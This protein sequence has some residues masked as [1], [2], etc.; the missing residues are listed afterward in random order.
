M[1]NISREK[2]AIKIAAEKCHTLE[3][4]ESKSDNIDISEERNTYADP[5]LY[6][7]LTKKTGTIEKCRRLDLIK[8]RE[9]DI[10]STMEEV[11]FPVDLKNPEVSVVIPVYNSCREL[12]ECLLSVLKFSP[13]CSW[14]LIIADDCSTE[15]HVEKIFS[16]RQDLRYIKQ[17]ENIGF[18]KNVNNAVAEAKGE[19]I[20]L[21][22]SDVQLLNDI[23]T[24][25]LNEIGGDASVGCIGPKILFPDGRL[26]EAGGRIG[27]Y[28][29]MDMIGFGDN[30]NKNIYNFARYVD[31]ISGACCFFRKELFDELN[32]LDINYAPAYVEDVDFCSRI[33]VSGKKI[34][35]APQAEIVHHLSVS[36]NSLSASL[37]VVQ[38][39]ANREKFIGKFARYYKKKSLLKVI[40][41]YLPQFHPCVE[42]DFWWGK[43]YTE[44]VATAKASPLFQGHYQPHVPAELGFYNLTDPSVFEKQA[45][46]ARR[47][48]VFGFCFYYYN[49][50]GRELLDKALDTFLMSKADINFCLCWAN[51]NWTRRWD[52]QD[53]EILMKQDDR[54]GNYCLHILDG[55]ERFI[56]D[57]RYIRIDGRPLVVIYRVSL[58]E[59]VAE[60]LLNWREYWRNQHDEELYIC[61]V[62][63]A[64]RALGESLPP[65]EMGFDAAVEFPV[66]NAGAGIE[67]SRVDFFQGV[68]CS[69]GVYDYRE[70]VE[71]ICSRPHPGYKRFPGCFPSWD[72][73]PRK[74]NDFWVFNESHPSIFQWFVE[75]KAK[76]ADVLSGDEKMLFVNAWNEWGEGAHIEPDV[77]YGHSWLQVIDRV[78]RDN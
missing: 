27:K 72:N 73:T 3:S 15:H 38:S 17:K 36:Y 51:E 67:Q 9:E 63:S 57:D 62:D 29:K 6:S 55:F 60:M 26:Q 20:L 16:A 34:F 19:Y 23:V 70:A 50:N 42:N 75:Q 46:L 31:Y 33:T 2:S 59:N 68:K 35:Y 45:V 74:K 37:K 5:K 25:F 52:G 58:L 8:V 32:G 61:L 76:E 47:Y 22:N 14:E 53:S 24:V 66:H 18:L 49:F 40:A 30:P 48:N 4:P 43:N 65:D 78:V 28:C 13:M 21:L 77:K 64:E 71:N 11:V 39:A 44:W 54:A 1:V 56:Q 41:F 10:F 7:S 69:G 12:I